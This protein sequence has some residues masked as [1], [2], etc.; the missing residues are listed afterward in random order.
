MV[1]FHRVDSRTPGLGHPHLAPL[2]GQF[3]LPLSCRSRP[4]NCFGILVDLTLWRGGKV[5]SRPAAAAGDGTTFP[6]FG[7]RETAQPA[8]PWGF[9]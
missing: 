7:A 6:R 4:E 1:D 9:T 5:E 2:P 8:P 3:P